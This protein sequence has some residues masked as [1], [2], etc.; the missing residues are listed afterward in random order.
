MPDRQSTVRWEHD[1]CRAHAAHDRACAHGVL[2]GRLGGGIEAFIKDL[3]HH[4]HGE[5]VLVMAFSE[6]GRRVKENAS[7][8]TDHGAA[9][10]LFL[11]GKKSSPDCT[12]NLSA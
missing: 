8:G 7:K 9:A 4:G 11:V 2:L 3:D 5:R 10:P 12:V 6:F 1:W